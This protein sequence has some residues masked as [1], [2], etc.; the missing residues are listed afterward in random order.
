MVEK[1]NGNRYS[2]TFDSL[3]DFWKYI[4][5]TPF[6][7]TFRWSRHDSVDNSYSFTQT[8]S[9]DEAVDLFHKGWSTMATRLDKELKL[10]YKPA[11]VN[12]RVMVNSVAGFQAIVP[13][14]LAGVPTSMVNTKI[15]PVKQKVLNI[16][17]LINYNCSI[18]TETI[19]NESIKALT[20][21]KRLE[22][23]GYRCNLYIGWGD[24]G[25]HG[26]GREIVTKIKIKS[27]NEKLN[28]SKLA[29]PLVHP[30]MLRR[31]LFRLLEVY[32]NVTSEFRSGYGYPIGYDTMKKAFAD[33]QIVLPSIWNVDPNKLDSLE[34]ITSSF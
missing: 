15:V 7:E 28:I 33:C 26:A 3:G 31:L 27:S 18:K 4:T 6:N 13:L 19:V 8:H 14:Y 1:V 21:V 25:R 24:S 9:F 22:Q 16:V 20:V 32:P 12:K 2:L 34:Q 11:P 10:Q 30:S 5:E 23:Q 29:F 17:K